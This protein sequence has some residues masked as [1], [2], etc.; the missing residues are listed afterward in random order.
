MQTIGRAA[1]NED[2]KVIMYADTI[3]QS[4]ATAIDETRRRRSIQTEYN[5]AHNI[6]P[7]SVHKSKEAIL[8]QTKVGQYPQAAQ[9]YMEKEPSLAAD[10]II[11]Y[12]RRDELDKLIQATE[13]KMLA[14]ADKLDFMEAE[15]L[16]NELETL[17]QI[18]ANKTY[19]N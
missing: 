17:K 7:R 11:P 8:E 5:I 3:T 18:A 9:Y 10:P 16:K 2:G 14:A 12:M 6:T 15:R 13:K 19:K 1:R 4:M